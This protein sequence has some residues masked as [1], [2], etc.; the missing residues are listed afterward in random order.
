MAQEAMG[1]RSESDETKMIVISDGDIVRNRYIADEG[2][3]L[4]L[5]YDFYTQTQYANKELLL[6]AV[7]YLVGDEGLMASRSRNIKLRKL[8]VMKVKEE[9]LKYQIINVALPVVILAVAGIVIIVARRRKYRK[10]N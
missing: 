5:G 2:A 6:N 8:D 7:N 10:T 9:S 4:P 1:F 3:V